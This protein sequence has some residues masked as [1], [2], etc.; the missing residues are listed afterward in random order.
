VG[1]S[2]S[3]VREEG[4][5][6]PICQ[7]DNNCSACYS[8]NSNPLICWCRDQEIPD[9]LIRSL[10]RSVRGQV[11]VCK[12]C[13]SDYKEGKITLPDLFIKFYKQK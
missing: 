7:R 1:E 5:V 2:V 6:C 12:K 3:P 10:P 9:S 4:S 13:I 8:S 11:C